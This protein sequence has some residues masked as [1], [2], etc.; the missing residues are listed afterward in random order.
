MR[1]LGLPRNN[2]SRQFKLVK[3]VQFWYPHQPT[4][5][6]LEEAA[7]NGC[8]ICSDVLVRLKSE[9]LGL[10]LKE[11]FDISAS[12]INATAYDY[13]KCNQV[14]AGSEQ[15]FVHGAVRWHATMGD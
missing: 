13:V 6:R 5:G 11:A 14:D 15:D 9:Y 10:P 2:C 12:P 8:Q 3:E 4:F 1:R 7:R